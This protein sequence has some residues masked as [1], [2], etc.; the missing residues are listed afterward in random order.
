MHVFPPIFS[1]N[2][3]PLDV[4]S[5]LV[6]RYDLWFRVNR[7]WKDKQCRNFLIASSNWPRCYHWFHLDYYCH[8][9]VVIL[10]LRRSVFCKLVIWAQSILVIK[11]LGGNSKLGTPEVGS[12]TGHR[13]LRLPNRHLILIRF[14]C[15][16]DRNGA[17]PDEFLSAIN[18]TLVCI[19]YKYGRFYESNYQVQ[20]FELNPKNPICWN[21]LF[22]CRLCQ[23]FFRSR[24]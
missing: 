4:S 22:I 20:S 2:D 5:A 13:F 18:V 6:A 8:L 16:Y 9:S 7:I 15:S 24:P 17:V 14:R 3:F 12:Q 19:L 11:Q 1:F 21:E 10:I 23:S